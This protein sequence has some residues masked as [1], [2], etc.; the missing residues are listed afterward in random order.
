MVEK[1]IDLKD[2]ELVQFLGVKN[3]NIQGIEEAFP[4]TKI[5]SRG[6]K[7]SIKGNKDQLLEVEKIITSLISHFDKYGSVDIKVVQSH[8]RDGYSNQDNEPI[9]YGSNGKRIVAKTKN[10]KKIVNLH[11]KNDLLFVIGPAGTGKTYVSVALGVKALK[12]KK[13]KKIIITR[14]VVEAGESLGFL[15]GD[16]QDKIDPYLKPIYDALEDM[17]PIQKMKKFIENKTIEIAPLAYMRGRTLKN[18][19]ILLDEAQNT[20][21]SQLKMFLTRLGEDSKMIVTGDISQI[22]LRKDQSSGLIDAKEKLRDINGIG[23]TLLN[24]SDVLRH[25]LVKKIL[26]KYKK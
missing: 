21:K 10:Q 18:A 8:I 17:I 26:D 2:I 6:N 25:R 9:V 1:T 20:T 5:I 11:K 19:F 15:P 3:K 14:P 13:V 24:S 16:L 12:E 4:K 7:I 22:D 23:F